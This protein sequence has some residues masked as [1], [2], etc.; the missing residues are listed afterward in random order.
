VNVQ[1]VGYLADFQDAEAAPVSAVLFKSAAE[2][3]VADADLLGERLLGEILV[4]KDGEDA[5][6]D[7]AVWCWCGLCGW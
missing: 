4:A 6:C 3:G 5:C 2:G 1:G 7:F